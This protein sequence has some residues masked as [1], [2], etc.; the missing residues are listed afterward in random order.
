MLSVWLEAF[1]YLFYYKVLAVN[2]VVHRDYQSVLKSSAL[3]YSFPSQAK[4]F[5]HKL[6]VKSHASHTAM[7]AI[8]HKLV[9]CHYAGIRYLF[10][11]L[12]SEQ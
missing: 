7:D 1:I 3:T 2:L 8:F 12:G 9:A 6:Q 4:K 10:F 11:R 5:I